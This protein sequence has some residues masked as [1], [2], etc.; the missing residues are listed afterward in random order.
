MKTKNSIQ[1]GLGRGHSVLS[2]ANPKSSAQPITIPR[3]LPHPEFRC[4][5]I[6][7]RSKSPCEKRWNTINNYRFDDPKLK[8][9]LQRGGNYGVC[10]GFGHLV[11][12]DADDP[13]I[14]EIFQQ[15]L[16][17][18][19]RVRS[20]SGRGFH[21]YLIVRGMRA[22]Q[23]FERN[24]KHLGE[25]QFLG[26]QLVGPGS[27]HPEGG[28]YT[29]VRDLP[30][31][32]VDSASFLKVFKGFLRPRSDR[33]TEHQGGSWRVQ[34]MHRSLLSIPLTSVIAVR[35]VRCGEEI[36]GAN[37]WHGSTTGRNFSLNTVRNVW[38]CFRC[39][40]GGGV[41]KAVALNEGII[42]RCDE[43]L[44]SE[45]FAEVLKIAQKKFLLVFHGGSIGL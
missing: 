1:T 39:N 3:H 34:G 12:L 38:H 31:L 35:G 13:L 32:E 15:R 11:G 8:A 45:A 14:S 17:P 42:R 29:V 27:L 33:A 30:I 22:K 23:V 36:H 26:Q 25:A 4:V 5:L 28:L 16:G 24:G 10:C 19:F 37:P 43:S 21:D 7:H 44:S 20:G 6:P 40:A 41:A 18:T 9:W 2:T